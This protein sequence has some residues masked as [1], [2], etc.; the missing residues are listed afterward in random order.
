MWEVK[1]PEKPK[2]IRARMWDC[3]QYDIWNSKSKTY[4]AS[5][6]NACYS[7]V[8]MGSTRV[9][10]RPFKRSQSDRMYYRADADADA[11]DGVSVLSEAEYLEWMN[12]A[13]KH[14]IVPASAKCYRDGDH[15]IMEIVHPEKYD[16]HITY[17]ALCCYR[18]SD[19]KAPMIYDIIT[20]CKDHPNINF[21]QVFQYCL[22]VYLIEISHSFVS[23]TCG[24]MYLHGRLMNLVRPTDLAKS[25]ALCQIF[26]R[27]KVRDRRGLANFTI[28]VVEDAARVTQGMDVVPKHHILDER[29]SVLYDLPQLD[30]RELLHQRFSEIKK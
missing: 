23:M 18:W 19:S 20:C 6:A 25:I 4:V 30:N 14:G 8:V 17:A 5:S 26:Q 22:S 10:C 16:R 12:L 11:V 15:N 29:W 2:H 21:W 1:L 24:T 3:V 28:K 9:R 27:L 7:G 13:K